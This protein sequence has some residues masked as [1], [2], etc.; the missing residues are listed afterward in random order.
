MISAWLKRAALAP[1]ALLA[2]L[3]SALA[4]CP[5]CTAATGAAVGVARIYGVDDAIMGVLIG[6]FLISSALWANN[7]LKRKGWVFFS[8]Q[9]FS[10]VIASLVFTIIGFKTGNLLT[11]ALLWGMPRLLSGMLLGSGAA[12]IGH[13]VH[14]YLRH[15]NAG[16]NYIPLQGMSLAL[17]SLL[18]C[19]ML[20]A[21]GFI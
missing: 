8:G 14:E 7:W 12:L 6:S 19:T 20:F 16:K 11:G 15:L 9:G 18:V 17:A 10:I 4:H 13:G 2:T 21:G 1:L 5:L 3:P